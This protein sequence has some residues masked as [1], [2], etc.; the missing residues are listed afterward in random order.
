MRERQISKKKEIANVFLFQLIERRTLPFT[1]L[2]IIEP[3]FREYISKFIDW[4]RSA[5][6]NERVQVNGR[7]IAEFWLIREMAA[8]SL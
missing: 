1:G 4:F 3:Y 6:L 5:V 8:S 2:Q 7:M